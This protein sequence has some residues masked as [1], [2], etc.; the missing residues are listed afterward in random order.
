MLG[1]KMV[2][3]G[4]WQDAARRGEQRAWASDLVVHYVFGQGRLNMF[5][6][7]HIK[8]EVDVYTV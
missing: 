4:R 6:D 7:R 3:A 2:A 5:V 1:A 8:M